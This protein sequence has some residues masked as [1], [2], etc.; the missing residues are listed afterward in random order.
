M[1]QLQVTQA[2]RLGKDF[3]IRGILLAGSFQKGMNVHVPLNNSLDLVGPVID[4]KY[5]NDQFEIVIGC[6]DQDEIELWEMLNLNG[7]TLNIT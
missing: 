3:L 1:A 7:D 5:D 6:S 4:I 2:S